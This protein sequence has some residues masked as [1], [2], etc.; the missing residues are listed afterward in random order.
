MTGEPLCRSSY[1]SSLLAVI[2][3]TSAKHHARAVSFT[4]FCVPSAG[5]SVSATTRIGKPS[6][7]SPL[8]HGS[9]TR[10]IQINDT[11]PAN[12][13]P[14]VD[15]G[16]VRLICTGQ[17]CMMPQHLL[18]SYYSCIRMVTGWH[19]FAEWGK[20]CPVTLC[21]PACFTSLSGPPRITTNG[22][23]C[24]IWTPTN[25]CLHAQR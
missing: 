17:A 8:F 2:V 16:L 6:D 24:R 13:L 20:Y 1:T 3:S 9:T 12:S 10:R 21:S 14:P 23:H 18:P 19:A 25:G 22:I 11:A 4:I 5:T 15:G 7:Q